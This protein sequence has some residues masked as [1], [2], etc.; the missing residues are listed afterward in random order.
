MGWGHEWQ[1]IDQSGPEAGMEAF[2]SKEEG[3]AKLGGQKADPQEEGREMWEEA[4]DD[5]HPEQ[6]GEEGKER[7]GSEGGRKEDKGKGKA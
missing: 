1:G 4:E 7:K 5:F 2:G 3:N 6:K